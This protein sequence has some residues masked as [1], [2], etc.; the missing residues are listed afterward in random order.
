MKIVL[1]F[2]HCKDLSLYMDTRSFE[3]KYKDKVACVD[4]TKNEIQL[5]GLY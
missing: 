1:E 3:E 5:K 2:N 4:W